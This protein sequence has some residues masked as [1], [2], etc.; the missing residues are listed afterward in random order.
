MVA[1]KSFASRRFRL[2]HAKKRSI[3]QRRAMTAKPTWLSDLRT[4]SMRM[5]LAL[6]TRGPA[7]PPSA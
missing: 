3:T 5:Q 2:I 6:A 1:L 7:Y 4:T